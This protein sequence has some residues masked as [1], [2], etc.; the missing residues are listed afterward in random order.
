[1]CLWVLS[2]SHSAVF[3]Y[4]QI[5]T[6]SPVLL[7]I[8]R[9][10]GHPDIGGK[11]FSPSPHW[12]CAF[13]WSHW[14]VSMTT[15]PWRSVGCSG[16]TDVFS[17]RTGEKHVSTCQ[18]CQISSLQMSFLHFFFF[19]RYGTGCFL[20]RNTGTKVNQWRIVG[21]TLVKQAHVSYRRSPFLLLQPVMSEHGL[22]TTVAYKLGRDKPAFYALE[23]FKSSQLWWFTVSQLRCSSFLAACQGSVA[24]AGAV[25][26]WLQDNLGI[27]GSSEELGTSKGGVLF[28]YFT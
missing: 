24:I 18:G 20:L 26:R 4:A 21:R 1:M 3:E 2:L 8:W 9:S 6:S 5:S 7:E 15:V 23:V 12:V 13:I 16:R 25:V 10:F 14:A 27:I 22:L 28:L 11:L 17:G 19:S